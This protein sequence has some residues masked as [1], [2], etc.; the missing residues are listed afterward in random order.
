M[1]AGVADLSACFNEELF[2]KAV[3]DRAVRGK[4][5]MEAGSV[6]LDNIDNDSDDIMFESSAA[7]A[8]TPKGITAS[9][10]SKVWCISKEDA[11]R[12][13][14][15]TTQLNKQDAD[16]S[17]ARR[18]GTNDRML[19]YRRINSLFYTDTFYSKQVLMISKRGFSMMQL[20]VSDKGFVKV[21]GMK[22]ESE[23]P[24]ALKLFCKEVEAPKAIVVD[25][26]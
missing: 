16:A 25:L 26:S 23:F 8:D 6:C 5:A 3:T 20:F 1:Q 24:D 22:S 13:L 18:F 19:R 10:L 17:L 21:Y 9:Q 2:S 15:V 11:K 4:L 14:D 12:T 7:H